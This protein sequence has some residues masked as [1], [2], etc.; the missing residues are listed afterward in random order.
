MLDD[1]EVNSPSIVYRIM[2]LDV[3]KK[4]IISIGRPFYDDTIVSVKIR[5]FEYI[6]LQQ[7]DIDHIYK[8]KDK[9]LMKFNEINLFK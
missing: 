8:Y 6:E 3:N 5:I 4:L 1:P 9:K 2:I 7:H